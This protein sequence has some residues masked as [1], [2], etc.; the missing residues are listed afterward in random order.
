MSELP[1]LHHWGYVDRP[2]AQVEAL[3]RSDPLPLMNRATMSAAAQTRDM[4]AR[5][6]GSV[7]SAEISADVRT[8]VDSVRDEPPEPGLPP[9][10]SLELHWE[11]AREPAVF[12]LLRG[13]LSTWQISPTDTL[14]EIDSEYRP[15]FGF[16]GSAVDAAFGNRIVKASVDKFLEDLLTQI[17]SSVKK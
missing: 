12:P 2:L 13:R 8:C 4:V 16:L 7:G 15:R 10:M 6:S 5:L 14:V 11:A 1:R 9:A 17:R 3:L